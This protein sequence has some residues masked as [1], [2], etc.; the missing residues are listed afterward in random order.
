MDRKG[1]E[2]LLYSLQAFFSKKMAK[3][4]SI[5]ITDHFKQR[6]GNFLSILCIN[7]TAEILKALESNLNENELRSWIKKADIP[8]IGITGNFQLTRSI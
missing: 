8:S 3:R 1:R 4:P 7:S 2:K 6:S 5:G